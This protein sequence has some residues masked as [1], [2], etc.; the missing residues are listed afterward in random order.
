MSARDRILERL[1]S[2]VPKLP[3]G[4]VTR[5]VPAVRA[6]RDECV[7][8][9]LVEAAALGVE[10][11]VEASAPAVRARLAALTADKHVLSWDARHLPYDAAHVLANATLGSDPRTTQANAEIGVTACDAAVAETGSLVLFSAPGRSRTVSL[12]PPVHIAIVEPARLCYSMGELF[13]AYGTRLANA[14][15][16]TVITGPSRTADIELTLT[17]GIHGPGKVVVIFGP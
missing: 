3:H 7:S 9:F 8:R 15:S 13:A 17:L 5:P 16:C 14:A 10:C 1:R 11:F 6:T 2:V 4:E 12:L